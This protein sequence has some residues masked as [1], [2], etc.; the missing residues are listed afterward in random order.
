MTTANPLEE[1]LA[2]RRAAGLFDFSF[3]GHWEIAGSGALEFLQELQTRNVARVE[4]G[5][6]VYTLLLNEAGGVFID[7]TVWRL[8]AD[9]FWLF[10][11]RRS[12]A[13]W[14]RERSAGR[15]APADRSGEQAVLALQGPASGAI[16]ARLAGDHLVRALRYFRFEHALAAG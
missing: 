1:H 7:A 5:R 8:E 4:P 15:C 6:L 12:D 13:A 14:L 3:M 10:T 9:R 16:L 2:T 11:G